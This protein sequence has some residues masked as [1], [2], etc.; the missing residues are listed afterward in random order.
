MVEVETKENSIRIIGGYGPQENWEEK[1][2][3][4]FFLALEI[5]IEKAE[6]EGKSIVIEIDANSKLGPDYIPKDPH[7]MSPNGFLLSGIIKRHALCVANGSEKSQGTITRR[8]VTQGRTEESIID[9]VMFSHDMNPHFK[10]L[11]VDEEKRHVL[12]SIRKTKRGIKVKESDHHVIETEFNYEIMNG[13]KK[14]ET[15]IL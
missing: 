15:R 12:K 13:N 5:E 9:I 3:L 10:S 4:P 1:K 11:K 2:R 6:L 7:K 8:R 14:T